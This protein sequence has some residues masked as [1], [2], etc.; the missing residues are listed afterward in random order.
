MNPEQQLRSLR[1]QLSSPG[2]VLLQR[3]QLADMATMVVQALSLE[4]VDAVKLQREGRWW[5]YA[6]APP[7]L[8][9][10]LDHMLSEQAEVQR[11]LA[12]IEL[13]LSQ[14]T[15]QHQQH[16]QDLKR[17]VEGPPWLDRPLS[18]GLVSALKNPMVFVA[19]MGALTSGVVLL[20]L[21]VAAFTGP[22]ALLTRP[23][24]SYE[25]LA[26]WLLAPGVAAAAAWR[27]SRVLHSHFGPP[28]P[29]R[30]LP[31]LGVVLLCG[32]ALAF[33]MPG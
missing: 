12:L 33:R 8:G 31:L 9:R 14:L 4:P 24:E 25:L 5:D 21:V 32:A 20:I 15:A 16:A 6:P 29:R 10:V 2:A 3:P 30:V 7:E 13:G 19:V 27:L 1:D 23:R 18:S 17:R 28:T 22:E 26:L 11:A